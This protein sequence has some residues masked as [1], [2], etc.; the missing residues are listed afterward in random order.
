MLETCFACGLMELEA[1]ASDFEKLNN[2]IVRAAMKGPAWAKL[3]AAWQDEAVEERSW[4][5]A[6]PPLWASLMGSF[7]TRYAGL[8]Q[9]EK[10]KTAFVS[11]Y[12]VAPS[13]IPGALRDLYAPTVQLT[14][15]AK[16]QAAQAIED[17]KDKAAAKLKAALQAAGGE[18]A[19]GAAEETGKQTTNW[20]VWAL[21]LGVLGTVGYFIL[22]RKR[23]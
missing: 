18:M 12:A 20:A 7:W 16:R 13:G 8:Y 23:A 3:N 10:N 4:K 14:E 17:A 22:R 15:Q 5:M 2:A 11:P 1:P 19:K 6:I 21:G 9:A